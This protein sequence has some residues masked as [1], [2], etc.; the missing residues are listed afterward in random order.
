MGGAMI[1]I[2]KINQYCYEHYE[3]GGDFVVETM[4][5]AEKVGR[6]ESTASL[7]AW[8]AVE[9]EHRREMQSTVG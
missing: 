3:E 4:N 7:Q 8:I 9:K 5:T 1:T 6:F 2:E